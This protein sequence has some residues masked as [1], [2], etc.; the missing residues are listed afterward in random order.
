[1]GVSSRAVKFFLVP[2]AATAAM[3]ICIKAWAVYQFWCFPQS[4]V[5]GINSAL[6]IAGNSVSVQA[7][8]VC[9]PQ[10]HANI[11][12]AS[13]S[14]DCHW[15]TCTPI[16]TIYMQAWGTNLIGAVQAQANWSKN[17]DMSNPEGGNA[18]KDYCDAEIPN[19]E[20]HFGRPVTSTCSC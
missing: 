11:V 10:P 2:A 17:S 14:I 18:F 1:M 16:Y 4:C 13:A 15:P 5:D 7:G 3:L 8:G 20:M 9:G 19:W 6:G 12:A